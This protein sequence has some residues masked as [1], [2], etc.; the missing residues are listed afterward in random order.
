M[1]KLKIG[2][3][4]GM[5]TASSLAFSHG[6]G[7]TANGYGCTLA[8]FSNEIDQPFFTR[9]VRWYDYED[10][11]NGQYKRKYVCQFNVPRQFRK[12]LWNITVKY[13]T[14]CESSDGNEGQTYNAEVFLNRT[15]LLMECVVTGIPRQ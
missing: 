8:G 5:L 12:S 9:N 10:I 13:L 15:R 11:D 7:N 2:L 4:A 1:N 3:L 14:G 6:I